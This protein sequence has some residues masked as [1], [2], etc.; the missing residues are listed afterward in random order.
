MQSLFGETSNHLD[1]S[2]SLQPRFGTLQLLTFPKTQIFQT[3][4]EI[5]ENTMGQLMAIGRTVC[6]TRVNILKGTEAS[7]SYVQCF[8]F[9]VS[10]LVNVFIFHIT[11][12]DTFWTDLVLFI[13]LF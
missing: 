1:D 11:W 10:S 3:I 7:L 12:M 8:L 9:L 13:Y 2:A 5:H 6:G 4:S